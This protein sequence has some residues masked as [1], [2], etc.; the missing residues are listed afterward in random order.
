[1]FIFLNVVGVVFCTVIPHGAVQSNQFIDDVI[2][3]DK[4]MLSFLAFPS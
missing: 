2:D 4:F 3:S 1:M